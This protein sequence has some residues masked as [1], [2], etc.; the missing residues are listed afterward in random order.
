MSNY[1]FIY[2]ANIQLIKIRRSLLIDFRSIDFVTNVSPDGNKLQLG[3][4]Y[5]ELVMHND[6]NLNSQ[7]LIMGMFF[8]ISS[9]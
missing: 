4:S 1:V 5:F 9:M 6:E 8:I 2:I 3:K 7:F